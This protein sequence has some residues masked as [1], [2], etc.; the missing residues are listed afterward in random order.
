[1]TVSQTAFIQD[2]AFTAD[3]VTYTFS[4]PSQPL[5]LIFHYPDVTVTSLTP[6]ETF[7][8]VGP[9][10]KIPLI[11]Q[12]QSDFGTVGGEPEITGSGSGTFVYSSTQAQC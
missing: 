11:L 7:S 8:V 2:T 4:D 10:S 12:T 3:L 1:M 9:F 6:F 5:L